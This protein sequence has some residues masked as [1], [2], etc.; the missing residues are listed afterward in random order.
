MQT[1]DGVKGESGMIGCYRLETS[2]NVSPETREV[3]K[4]ET[5]SVIW[6]SHHRQCSHICETEG[7]GYKSQL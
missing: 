3:R 1:F 2:N 6:V 4:R 5:L 7:V